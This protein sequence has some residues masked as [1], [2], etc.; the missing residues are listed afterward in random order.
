M[1]SLRRL[2]LSALLLASATFAFAARSERVINT[3]RPV[4]YNVAI[5]LNDG[6]TEITRAR[7]EVSLQILKDNLTTVDLDFGELTV[8]AVTIG[9][10]ATKFDQT[11]GLLNVW[12]A[13]GWLD[14]NH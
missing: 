7:T 10:K 9:G 3:W 8:D 5:T 12:P 1:T 2:L 13:Q 4:N 11:P 6:L 14:S